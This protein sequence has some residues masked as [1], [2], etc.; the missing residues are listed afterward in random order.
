VTFD[1][2]ALT[3]ERDELQSE[4]LVVSELMQQSIYEN[5]R[6]AIDQTEY[7]KRYDALTE[8]YD[9]AKVCLEEIHHRNKRQNRP[10]SS[11]RIFCRS[12]SRW[13]AWSPN[14]TQC[15]GSAL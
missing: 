2:S 15:S 3:A 9:K 8:R 6:V 11:S 5:A 1:L 14:L 4:T 13:T 7:Q 10:A 12:C